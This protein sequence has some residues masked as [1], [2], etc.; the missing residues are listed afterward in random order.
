MNEYQI[1]AQNTRSILVINSKGYIR[2]LYCP[3]RVQCILAIDK[4]VVG[5]WVWVDKVT[6]SVNVVLLYHIHG[7]LY[8]FNHFAIHVN[9]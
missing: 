7:N 6:Y 3:F 9:F 4:I 5:T 2:E 8:S 1:I